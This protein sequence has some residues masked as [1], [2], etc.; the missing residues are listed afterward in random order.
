[1]APDK[2]FE[3]NYTFFSEIRSL[4]E[5]GISPLMELRKGLRMLPVKLTSEMVIDL[6]FFKLPMMMMKGLE[7]LTW[8]L[9]TM[10]SVRFWKLASQTQ[11]RRRRKLMQVK[12]WREATRSAGK[13]IEAMGQLRDLRDWRVEKDLRAV[14]EMAMSSE[15]LV[16]RMEKK[17]QNGLEESQRVAF[18]WS[19]HLFCCYAMA[20]PPPPSSIRHHTHHSLSHVTT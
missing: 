3:D 5:V 20:E 6:S 13:P 17:W 8:M 15:Q 1:M 18:G 9:E 11:V 7:A 14:K 10:S 12:E 16:R 2:E 19:R 4:N